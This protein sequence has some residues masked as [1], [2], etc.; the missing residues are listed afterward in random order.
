M[1][2]D[3]RLLRTLLSSP[4]IVVVQSD[5]DGKIVDLSGGA[6]ELYGYPRCE[7][8]GRPVD[9]LLPAGREREWDEVRRRLQSGEQLPVR[10]TLRRRKDGAVLEVELEELAL[11]D[12]D[13][14][15]S[16]FLSIVRE[17]RRTTRIDAGSGRTLVE[18]A[19][20]ASVLPVT[21]LEE[22]T[23][24]R[25]LQQTVRSEGRLFEAVLQ[26]MPLALFSYDLDGVCTSSR[27]QALA[28]LGLE[29]GDLVGQDLLELYDDVPEVG[30]AVLSSLQGHPADVVRTFDGRTWEGHYRPLR[31][32][33]GRV[34]G[35]LG[36]AVDVTALSKAQSEVRAND[37]RLRALLRHA[38]DVVIV[39]DVRG[40]LLY[41]SPA[42][43]AQFGY[44]VSSLFWQRAW[45]F[46]HPEDRDAIRA[47][48]RRVA[49]VDGRSETLECRVLHADGTYRWTEHRLTNLLHDEDI[50]GVV[51]NLRDITEQR[52]AEQELRRLAV[53]DRLTGLANRTLL[54][55]RV[56][57]ALRRGARLDEPVGLVLL[58]V[59][60]LRKHNERLGQ[61]GGDAV[62]RVLAQRLSAAV[63]SGDSVAR[64]GDDEFAVLYED[65]SSTE[66][67]RARAAV[68]RA[69]VQEPLAVDGR[70][71]PLA[72]QV[73]VAL[74]PAA[75]AGALL[76]AAEASLVGD[77]R[78]AGWTILAGS[79]G[80]AAPAP[81]LRR[82]LDQ[83][84]LRLHYQ[85]VL[86]LEDGAVDGVEAL[87]RWQHPERGLLPPSQFIPLAEATGL[88]IELGT[89]ALHTACEAAARWQAA[90]RPL[91]VGVNLSPRQV[92][93]PG[94]E[95]VVRRVLDGTGAAPERLVLEV[96]ESALMD[97][98]TALDTLQALHALGV[99][100][101]LDDFGTGY[102]SF[103]Y[104]KRFPVDALKIDRSFV[105]GLG[106]DA[107]DEAIVASV[108]SL[109]RS[110]GKSVVAEGVET[111][112]QLRTLRRLGV[113]R[114][115]GFLW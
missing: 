27:G 30:A 65:A 74:S 20:R 15:V 52:R 59:V 34:V 91:S 89:W 19:A 95:E 107:D 111:P 5:V 84:E 13:G 71:V 115:Q 79:A 113:D 100:L 75:D 98:V 51:L 112:G 24:F 78:P 7:L 25:A 80:G 58:D 2:D 32:D 108:V 53:E 21:A 33:D 4:V 69:A 37:A 99:Q 29:D 22:P 101:A 9:V 104:L 61:A 110:V 114:A 3:H 36:I 64:V 103:T 35:G 23:E 6:A 105:A 41:V 31:D 81:E 72:L 67:L 1:S 47:A 45:G 83:R 10:S 109:G 18:R 12:D 28:V 93:V 85:P 60:G 46:G 88:V 54:L 39:V 48:W 92:A 70:E 8:R 73:G 97:S 94:F 49:E 56:G 14:A 63:R 86:G 50:A 66:D 82:A 76:A 40:R 16:G 106:R 42:I 55:D 43:E 77:G 38:T 62:L 44:E 102:S 57:H 90:G 11:H 17:A 26:T 68:L 96:T 87:V